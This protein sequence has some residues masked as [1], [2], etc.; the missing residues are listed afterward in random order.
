MATS[1]RLGRFP[2]FPTTHTGQGQRRKRCSAVVPKKTRPEA[3]VPRAGLT[4]RSNC[5][6][7]TSS[8]TT[9]QG[10]PQLTSLETSIR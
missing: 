7:W 8:I 3:P 10:T 2:S 1:M 6:A 5:W 4:T 9:S